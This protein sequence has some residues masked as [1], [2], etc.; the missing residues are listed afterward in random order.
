LENLKKKKVKGVPAYGG[1]GKQTEG[2]FGLVV[3]KP[4]KNHSENF[5]VSL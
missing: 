4:A 3:A 1:P 5:P 2:F